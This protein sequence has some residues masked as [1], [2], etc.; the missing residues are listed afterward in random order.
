MKNKI[1][2]LSF[3]E[4]KKSYKRFLSLLIMS[5]LGVAIFVGMRNAKNVM[6]ASLDTYYDK[7]N[8][9]DIKLVSTL[10][11]SDDDIDAIKDIEIV[12]NA[13]GIHSKDIYFYHNDRTYVLKTCGINNNIN[14]ISLNKGDYPKNDNEILV[15]DYL[16]KHSNLNIGD[17]INV[18]DP[19]SNI[20]IRKFKIVGTVTSP[21]YLLVG[22]PQL[23]RDTSN[24][25]TGSANYYVYTKDNIYNMDYYSEVY[26]TIKNAKK[27]ITSQ[28]NYNELIDKGLNEI[29][30]IKKKREKAR[31]EEIK[32]KLNNEINENE[33][34][35]RKELDKASNEL[36]SYKEELENGLYQLNYNK[37]IIN[38][39]KKELDDAYILLKS[40]KEEIDNGKKQLEIARAEVS[41]AKKEVEEKISKY[42]LTIDD[43]YTIY[44]ILKGKEIPKDEFK[45]LVKDDNKYKEDIYK[46]IDYLYD[47]DYYNKINDFLN[48]N[49]E[50]AKEELIK[51]IPDSIDNYDK[52]IE[53]IKSINLE[54]I[55]D[56]LYKKIL[57]TDCIDNLKK[58]IPSNIDCY[59]KIINLLDDY[60]SKI[61][62]I[63]LLFEVVVKIKNALDEINK[64]EA[65]LN[66]GI[67][68]YNEAY[69]K[70]LINLKKLYDG[71]NELKI[72]YGKYYTNKELFDSKLNEFNT[73][74]IDFEK[75]FAKA[76]ED[77]NSL[78]LPTWYLSIRNDC[79]DYSSYLNA[80]D[81]IDNLSKTF[82]TIFFIVAIFMSIM[83]MSRMALEDRIE[84][85]SLKSLGY[86]N[87]SIMSKYIIYSMLATIIG[88]ILGALFGFYFLTYFLWTLY[89]ILYVTHTF[90][91][92]YDFIPFILGIIL[93]VICICGTTI[94]TIKNIVKENTAS[95]LRPKA[96]K[97]GKKLLI[98]KI[99]I[100]NKIKFSNKITIRN[101][102]R[103][104][105]RVLLTVI[106]IAGCTV[107]LLSGYGI[108]DS[109]IN[110]TSKHFDEV[111]AFDDIVYHNNKININ[112]ELFDN[113]GIDSIVNSNLLVAKTGIYN[114]NV[115]SF[116]DYK[117]ISSIIKLKSTKTGK[118]IVLKDDL[119]VISSKLAEVLKINIGDKIKISDTNNN[120]Y[121]FTINDIYRNYIGH[122]LMMNKYTYE[123]YIGS[124]SNNVM[125]LKFNNSKAE[126][127]IANKLIEDENV[128]SVSNVDYSKATINNML[129][130]LDKVVYI[131]IV[132]SGI[133]SFVVL[134]NLSYI[135]ISERKREIA[136]LKVLGFYNYEVDNYIIK[137]N[138][139]ITLLGIILGIIL[140][141]IF[142]FYIVDSI[143]IDLVNFLHQIDI[144][145][146]IKTFLFM[147]GFTVIVSFIIH[148]TLKKINMIDS[149][150]SV[151]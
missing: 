42:Q 63:K 115:A 110:I 61:K 77:I 78:E 69:N 134:Y 40:A 128:L 39:G 38:K 31:F 149:L 142:A 87:F 11:L 151:E 23:I 66:N 92:Y 85:G 73:Q 43:I 10:G 125:Y 37:N 118:N 19:D 21:L 25:G 48:G 20:K 103:Y 41:K 148:N 97:D 119:V 65:K 105:N 54:D 5:F 137:E 145:S 44:N 71:E 120:T 22:G 95:L 17:Y 9:Y 131:L 8:V 130:S 88:G 116:D 35:G 12:E 49:L 86:N 112:D 101:V 84:I 132:F 123:K 146:Y 138:F 133:L 89:S 126:K 117:N 24:I 104:K 34:N 91:Y 106:G 1:L 13:Y 7:N 45:K 4:I 27:L 94:L 67:N 102:F 144:M 16:L 81:S 111:M 58:Y 6:V 52:I 140:G 147:I 90:S 18:D 96:P 2:L 80:S 26:I 14:K 57:D 59:D 135:N 70:Y 76:R 82:P 55:R 64:N 46:V 93:A 56:I 28:K 51:I 53:F 127:E 50:N 139:I 3:R 150:K 15:E 114:I 143:E 30:K 129:R 79:S 75:K 32:N 100:W 36:M 121:S 136:S 29:T 109:I 113:K 141:R 107:L 62:D 47:N 124:Y 98:E 83:S 108:R 122:Y 33:E 74:K 68:E 72:G 60:S 99:K